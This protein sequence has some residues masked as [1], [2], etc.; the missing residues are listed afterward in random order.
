MGQDVRLT[1]IYAQLLNKEAI[2]SPRNTLVEAY[3]SMHTLA[4][5][6]EGETKK[7]PLEARYIT[8]IADA[9]ANKKELHFRNRKIQ[10]SGIVSKILVDNEELP[11]EKWQSWATNQFAKN[12]QENVK[13]TAFN[14]TSGET[15]N[16]QDLL[17]TEALSKAIINVGDAAEGILG[18]AVAAKFKAG[19]KDIGP[20]EIIEVL[21]GAANDKQFVTVTNYMLP[22]IKEDQV[23]FTL[24]LNKVAIKGLR[25]FTKEPDPMSSN[26]SKFEL[27]WQDEVAASNVISI[28]NLVKSATIYANKNKQ[29]KLAIDKAKQDPNKNI[30][31]IVSDGGEAS[32]QKLTKVDL[33]LIYDGKATRLLSLKAGKVRQFGQVSGAGFE[34]LAEFFKTTLGVEVPTTLEKAYK[35]KPIDDIEYKTHNYERG[36]I[37]NLYKYVEGAITKKLAGGEYEQYDLIETLYNAIA[38]HA[39]LKESGVAMVILTTD[40]KAGYKELSFGKELLEALQNY[41][42]NVTNAP[43]GPNHILYVTGTLK[44]TE[45]PELVK[46]AKE[47]GKP[48]PSFKNALFRLRTFSS[49]GAIRNVIEM[50]DLL[51]D[52]ADIEKIEKELN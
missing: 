33:K 1:N 38:H 52:L 12:K 29:I 50:G 16:L 15:F 43:G 14:L 13:K 25:S 5:I 39:T 42:F 3:N 46:K 32:N 37:A 18:A 28:Q 35:F 44:P 48:K 34:R 49:D 19:G 4:F 11:L 6:N 30:I 20:R 22:N 9:I 21:R 41:T 26:V 47:L 8:R 40:A 36:P 31:E 24:S 27:V 10:S 45:I 17:K 51:K 23:I 2:T 7:L